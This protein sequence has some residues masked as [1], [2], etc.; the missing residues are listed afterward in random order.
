MK[1]RRAWWLCWLC[2]RVAICPESRTPRTS[3]CAQ[4]NPG[5]RGLVHKNCASCHGKDGKLGAAPPLNDPVFLA[6]VPEDVLINVITA[7]RAGTEMPAF[8]KDQGGTLTTEQVQALATGL[9]NHWGK[10]VPEKK[11]WPPYIL[12]A[13][14]G[15]KDRGVTIF[16]GAANVMAERPGD[17]K[18]G[19]STTR[20]FDLAS[21]TAAAYCHHGTA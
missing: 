16:A 12:P 17:R 2:L 7:G 1:K 14:K 19:A 13:A 18:V 4:Q 11:D 3:S 20:R 6:I 9:H 5:F 21:R 15:D 8:A 10:A